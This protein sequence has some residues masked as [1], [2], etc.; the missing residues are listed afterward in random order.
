[1]NRFPLTSFQKRLEQLSWLLTALIVGW[2]L[3]RWQTLPEIVAIHYNAFG[4][5]DDWGGRWTVFLLPVI[6]AA[7]CGVVSFCQRLGLKYINLPFQVNME[8][9][10]YVLRAVRDTLSLLN[11]ESAI[12]FAVLQTHILIGK[13]LPLWFTWVMMGVLL[14][15]VV[16]GLWRAWTCNQGTL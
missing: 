5:A 8:R 6:L 10:W 16:F 4:A 13:N 7:L 3:L 2:T 9:E 14:S 11:V 15:T 12:T 1:M